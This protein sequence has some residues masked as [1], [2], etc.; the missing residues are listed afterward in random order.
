MLLLFGRDKLG[1]PSADEQ[2]ALDALTDVNRL[3]ELAPRVKD[4]RSWQ[5]LLGLP[6]PRRRPARRKPSS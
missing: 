5:E 4:A 1:E 2:A 6:G 3:E